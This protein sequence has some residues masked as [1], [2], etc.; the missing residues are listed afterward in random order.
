MALTQIFNEIRS[1][2]AWPERWRV[3]NV[4]PLFKGNGNALDPGNHR[5]IALMNVLPKVFEEVLH[6]R[7]RDWSE[8]VGALSDL[9]GGF[10]AGRGTMD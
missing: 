6:T 7:I 2:R 9:Q 4:I 8:R 5:M 3:A 1:T 10:R